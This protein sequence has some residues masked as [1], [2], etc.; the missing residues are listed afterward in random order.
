MLVS[1]EHQGGCQGTAHISSLVTWI[2]LTDVDSL[3]RR[4]SEHAHC[5]SNKAQAQTGLTERAFELCIV[6]HL[7]SVQNPL[8][9]LPD[10][11]L[12]TLE[13]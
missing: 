13:Y 10:L 4:D 11:Q 9:K 6:S 5:V 1:E 12:S 2:F 8:D 7:V 3:C